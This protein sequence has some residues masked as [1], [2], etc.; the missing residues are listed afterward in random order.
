MSVSIVTFGCRLN[1][2]ESDAMLHYAREGNDQDTGSKQKTIIVNTCTVTAEAER[3]ARQAI[4]KAHRENPG[5]RI[6]V[7][8]CASEREPE[9][10]AA[11]DGV[12]HLVPNG[13]K[14]SPASWG[15][16]PK[17]NL[18]PPPSR[19][20]RALLQVQQ[21]CDHRCT[22]CVIPYGR[23]A[24]KSLPLF[25]IISRARTLTEAGHEEIVLTGVDIASWQEGSYG[26]GSLCKALLKHVPAIKR[27]RLSSLD[28]V[29]LDARNGDR[30]FWD[31][32]TDEQR[33]MPH[34][35]LS[36]QAGSDLILKR[37]KRRHLTKDVSQS[38]EAIRKLRPDI[39]IGADL[40]A[41][42]PTETDE[43]FEETYHFIEENALPFLHV[44]PYSE[45]PGTPAARMPSLPKIVRQERAARL[46]NLG[47]RIHA[48]FL[49]RFIGQEKDVLL[50]T[51]T[52]GHTPEFAVVTL[53]NSPPITTGKTYRMRLLGIEDRKI[54]AEIAA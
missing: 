11:L 43:L 17:A 47:E 33:L 28:P 40:I 38:L 41:G 5:A 22:F 50:E 9:K 18:P 14:L 16:S 49:S 3:Q 20:T 8:G 25:D 53:V 51:Q 46:R 12:D 30:D 48:A 54:N 15:V 44:F 24:S 32:L 45:R 21:G 36:L 10:W 39:G 1:A 37:M 34:L 35:H 4:R 7:T 27:L 13:E 31:L 52:S 29:L 26:L 42:F 23:G 2:H 19:H 6:I